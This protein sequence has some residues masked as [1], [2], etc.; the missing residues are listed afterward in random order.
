MERALEHHVDFLN[1]LIEESV[2][3]PILI[4]NLVEEFIELSNFTHNTKDC[5]RYKEG[6]L[7]KRSGGRFKQEKKSFLSYYGKCCRIWEWR[8]FLLT[9]QYLM[10]SSTPEHKEPQDVLLI[11][12]DI[13]LV[14]DISETKDELAFW[15]K[16]RYR[17]LRLEAS[18][19]FEW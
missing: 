7:K 12:S 16:N 8:W 15:I 19:A 11:D 1:A 4:S 13:K 9:D 10:Y 5:I 17:E 6:W 2:N 18:D 3:M 14:T